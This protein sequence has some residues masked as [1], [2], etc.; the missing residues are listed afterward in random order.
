MKCPP[1][2]RASGALRPPVDGAEAGLPKIGV[3]NTYGIHRLASV[4][5]VAILCIPLRN[6]V[7]ENNAM[8]VRNLSIKMRQLHKEFSVGHASL[9]MITDKYFSYIPNMT[10]QDGSKFIEEYEKK[11]EKKVIVIG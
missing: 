2:L 8:M 11:V 7:Y 4:G 5:Q 1:G 6:S 10:H 9:K 3:A